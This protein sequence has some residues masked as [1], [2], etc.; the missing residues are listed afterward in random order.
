MCP[1][2]TKP[3]HELFFCLGYL[4]LFGEWSLLGMQCVA[5]WLSLFCCRGWS[6]VFCA[7]CYT[8]GFKR[9]VKGFS[10]ILIG[11]CVSREVP[12]APGVLLTLPGQ[13]GFAEEGG[14]AFI[15]CAG[16]QSEHCGVHSSGWSRVR[17]G[18]TGFS[19]RNNHIKPSRGLEALKTSRGQLKCFGP[20]RGQ[21]SLW[22]VVFLL[23]Q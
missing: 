3:L 19:G 17:R 8:R 14:S 7:Q 2:S 20:A 4:R 21:R 22:A 15:G 10:Y 18:S 11:D 5:G 13:Q 1:G 6:R 9:G 23:D 16:N 12:Q